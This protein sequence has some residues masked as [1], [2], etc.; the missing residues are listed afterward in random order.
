MS[1]RV[2]P[3]L[4]I[5]STWLGTVALRDADGLRAAFTAIAE[6]CHGLFVG[7]PPGTSPDVVIPFLVAWQ[8]AFASRVP[9]VDLRSVV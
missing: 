9:G 4:R 3:R 5:G 7:M 2:W 6:R 8:V 1:R